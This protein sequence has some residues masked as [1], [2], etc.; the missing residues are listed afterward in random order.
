MIRIRSK[1]HL[2]RR[3]GIAHPKEVVEYSD[4]RFS[5][6]EL[7]ILKAEPMLVVELVI[8]EKQSGSVAGAAGEIAAVTGE[9]PDDAEAGIQIGPE[10]LPEVADSGK[11]PV[12]AAKKGKR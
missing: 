1:R 12:K 7:A 6:A 4:D 10:D 2:F 8:P 9:R 3:C 5:E 11:Q